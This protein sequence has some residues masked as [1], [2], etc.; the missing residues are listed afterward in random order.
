MRTN[1][2][3]RKKT[4]IKSRIVKV[5]I[6][7][8]KYFFID[9]EDVDRSK[10]LITKDGLYSMSGVKTGC[11]MAKIIMNH[12][13]EHKINPKKIT[14]TDGTGNNGSETII[15]SRYFKK[16]NSIELDNV[17]YEVLKH[18]VETYNLKNVNIING[19]TTQKLK[20]LKQDVIVIDAPWGGPEYKIQKSIKLYMSDME[21]SDIV[22]NFWNKAKLF[23]L[24]VP[25]NYDFNYFSE[26][27][28]KN[29]KVYNY[30]SQ[31]NNKIKLK[32]IV[33]DNF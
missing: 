12:L 3:T 2:N 27:V 1:K 13:A 17:N 10:L 15:Y 5:P 22:N 4:N 32:I 6:E 7:L 23:V 18:N 14:I 26:K 20:S 33:L 16:V 30:I 24:K 9:K 28:Q 29:F 25:I 8:I 11:F 21:I 31:K 19:D